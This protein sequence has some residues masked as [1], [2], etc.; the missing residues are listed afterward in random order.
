MLR[1][2]RPFLCGGCCHDM[3]GAVGVARVVSLKRNGA[4]WVVRLVRENNPDSRA[5]IERLGF[6]WRPDVGN[7]WSLCDR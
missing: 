2:L 1:P 7:H 3:N 5:M 6:V 4:G